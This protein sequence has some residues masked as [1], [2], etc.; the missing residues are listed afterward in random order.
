MSPA[1]SDGTTCYVDNFSANIGGSVAGKTLESIVEV[2]V[3]SGSLRSM[4]LTTSV[5]Q[6]TGNTGNTNACA[7]GTAADGIIVPADGIVTLRTPAAT[8]GTASGA[9]PLAWAGMVFQTTAGATLRFR[10]LGAR[11]TSLL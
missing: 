11:E 5:S 8:L 4:V 2:Q 9:S 7:G 1:T 10:R 3:I 6:I